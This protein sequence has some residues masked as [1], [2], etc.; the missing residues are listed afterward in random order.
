MERKEDP[1]GDF[2]DTFVNQEY[3]QYADFFNSRGLCEEVGKII[4]KGPEE[5]EKHIAGVIKARNEYAVFVNARDRKLTL[6]EAI[7]NILYLRA[8]VQA[9]E[10]GINSTLT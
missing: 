5:H 6:F 3:M 4:A 7:R 10:K 2:F 1:I 9:Q 8:R